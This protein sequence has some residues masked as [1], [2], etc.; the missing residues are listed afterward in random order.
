MLA[1]L[2]TSRANKILAFMHYIYQHSI[3]HR[4]PL[5]I[6]VAVGNLCCMQ[7]QLYHI[8]IVTPSPP[9]PCNGLHKT[10]ALAGQSWTSLNEHPEPTIEPQDSPKG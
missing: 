7:S 1:I 6:V 4:F 10:E 8:N 9:K 2:Y 5:H 3:A